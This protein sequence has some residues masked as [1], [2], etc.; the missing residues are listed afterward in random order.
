MNMRL[1]GANT[2][3]DITPDMVDSSNISAHVAAIPG[4]R[5]YDSNCMY[6]FWGKSTIPNLLSF[7]DESM[8]HARL[9]EMKAK[10]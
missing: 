3:K 5:L 1:L 6:H 10:M 7:P 8:Q 2:I 4:D 9:R